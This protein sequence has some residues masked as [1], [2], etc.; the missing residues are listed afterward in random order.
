[1]AKDNKTKELDAM[2]KLIET[3]GYDYISK[4][5]FEVY[6]FLSKKKLPPYLINGITYFLLSSLDI[7]DKSKI[8]IKEAIEENLFLTD[9]LSE[10]LSLIF[11]SL[12]SKENKDKLKEK[13]YKGFEEFCTG[14][15]TI[16]L[17][18]TTYWHNQRSYKCAVKLE[19]T[20]SVKDG[21]KALS[22]FR[23]ALKENPFLSK[24]D[25]LEILKYELQS[26]LDKDFDNFCQMDYEYPPDT[27]D[28]T[29]E[30]LNA[31]FNEYGIEEPDWDF[32]YL[33]P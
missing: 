20:F 22:M 28:Y 15:H 12:Y 27:E 16:K 5:P 26:T 2:N 7:A 30:K 9:P 4:K 31:I 1:M 11:S 33:G 14:T 3:E 25:L 24:K 6:S 18:S 23:L 10:E 32:S 13:E 17:A 8:E 19:F 21:D 29:W